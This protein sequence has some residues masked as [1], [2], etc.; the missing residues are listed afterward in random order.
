MKLIAIALGIASASA[1]SPAHTVY[2]TQQASAGSYLIGSFSDADEVCA[3]D[4][5]SDGDMDV[6]AADAS[7]LVCLWE[8]TDGIGTAWSALIVGTGSDYFGKVVPIDLDD[9]GDIDLVSGDT[10]FENSDGLGETW[11]AHSIPSSGSVSSM[12]IADVDGDSDSDVV[13]AYCYWNQIRWYENLDGIGTQWASHQITVPPYQPGAQ[14][15]AGDLDGDG[16]IDIALYERDDPI[17]LVFCWLENTDGEG[18][19]WTTH[20]LDAFNDYCWD[21]HSIDVDQD[22]DNDILTAC[23]TGGIRLYRNLDG[24][25]G[26]W[27][28]LDVD[29]SA[30]QARDVEFADFD[31][32]G[33]MDVAGAYWSGAN[34]AVWWEN[35]DGSG[36]QWAEHGLGS[37]YPSPDGLCT[38]DIN[39]DGKPDIVIS[40][41][42]AVYWIELDSE[43]TGVGSTP[44]VFELVPVTPNPCSS[45]PAIEFGM[46]AAGFVELSVF[47]VTGRLVLSA[48]PSE[49][50]PGWHSVQLGELRPGVYFVRARTGEFEAAE[51]FVVL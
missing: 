14:V 2:V 31:L 16:D 42:T 8:N 3:A 46:P 49:Y 17:Y 32:D 18:E 4:V 51:R 12:S 11:I 29:G 35:L 10:W 22:G 36:S 20:S 19:S 34:N 30:S 21:L 41:S 28:V 33:D 38:T 37:G 47:E 48:G 39:C 44:A 26:S 50:Q 5:D 1:A 25:G 13:L 23:H 9:D 15:S 45:T 6:A 43:G 40:S 24:L 7:G 27:T